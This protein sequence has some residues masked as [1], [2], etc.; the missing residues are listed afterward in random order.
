MGE[1]LINSTKR[2]LAWPHAIRE[3]NGGTYCWSDCIWSSN[4]SSFDGHGLRNGAVPPC[5]EITYVNYIF[6]GV[7]D[8]HTHRHK[9][10]HTRWTFN[11]M[12][13]LHVWVKRRT[14]GW[15]DCISVRSLHSPYLLKPATSLQIRSLPRTPR[16]YSYKL[17]STPPNLYRIHK[18]NQNDPL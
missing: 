4:I 17:G 6:W 9:D 16:F 15:S 10:T 8:T 13:C 12:H 2:F 1:N 14:V 3:M 5:K 18:P 7:T 11:K